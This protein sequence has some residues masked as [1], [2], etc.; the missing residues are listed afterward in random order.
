MCIKNVGIMNRMARFDVHTEKNIV[1]E[2]ENENENE[3]VNENENK[4]YK[5]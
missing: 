4:K 5:L 3:N 2:N 1:N